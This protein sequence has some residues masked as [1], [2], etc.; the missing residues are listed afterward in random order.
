MALPTIRPHSAP[1][2][3]NHILTSNLGSKVD[4]ARKDILSILK[5]RLDAQPITFD[6]ALI[7][8]VQDTSWPPKATQDVQGFIQTM[9]TGLN[10]H[11]IPTDDTQIQGE[12]RIA[13]EH[14]LK[15]V[16]GVYALAFY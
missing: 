7:N 8:A 3:H 6:L 14:F 10:L 9:E 5:V 12:L 2:S 13:V 15:C 16:G 4:D 1:P 11:R